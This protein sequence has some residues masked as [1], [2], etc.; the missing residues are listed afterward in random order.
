MLSTGLITFTSGTINGSIVSQGDITINGGTIDASGS[1]YDAAV[2]I[3]NDTGVSGE[4]TITGSPTIRIDEDQK[5][6]IAVYLPTGTGTIDINSG[7]TLNYL[8]DDTPDQFAIVNDSGTSNVNINAAL[9]L[10]G[11][12]YS[13][14]DITLNNTQNIEGILVAGNTVTIGN[15]STITYDEDPYLKNAE[16]YKGFKGGRR[17]Y[18]PSSWKIMGKE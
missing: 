4:I 1:A 2:Y 10:I 8:P 13:S 14:G 5:A 15:N 7:F 12:I 11:S 3:Y 16:I 18:I 6:G 17:R 9:T